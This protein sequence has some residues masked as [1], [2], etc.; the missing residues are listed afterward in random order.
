MR[1]L[2]E[3]GERNG[4]ERWRDRWEDRKRGRDWR[5]G[6]IGWMDGLE[7]GQ[8][9]REDKSGGMG[10]MERGWDGMQ[11]D[12][13]NRERKGRKKGKEGRE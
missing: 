7:N 11:R 12:R 8:V 4:W 1:H 3:M 9:V 2:R 10:G 5:E 13:L 6:G